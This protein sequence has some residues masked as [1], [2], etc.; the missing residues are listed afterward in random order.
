MI[1][2]FCDGKWQG[3]A[4]ESVANDGLAGWYHH[5]PCLITF[6]CP[7]WDKPSLGGALSSSPPGRISIHRGKQGKTADI[8]Q[9]KDPLHSP[10]SRSFWTLLA[11]G[12]SL[13]P[14]VH[15]DRFQAWGCL[16]SEDARGRARAALRS[17]S[18]RDVRVPGRASP[19]VQWQEEVQARG[20]ARRGSEGSKRLLKRGE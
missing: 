11:A 9:E 20:R 8:R 10:P 19:M 16:L 6:T 12:V 1:F 5:F 18:A 15:R 17:T 4:P 3:D 14:Q 7:P 13:H 2:N